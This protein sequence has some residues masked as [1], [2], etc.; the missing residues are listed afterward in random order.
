MLRV[1]LPVW[2]SAGVDHDAAA[3]DVHTAEHAIVAW[4]RASTARVQELVL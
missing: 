4:S 3:A 1:F 2:A